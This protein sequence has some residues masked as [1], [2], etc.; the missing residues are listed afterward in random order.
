MRKNLFILILLAFIRCWGSGGSALAQ[1]VDITEG[2]TATSNG[3]VSGGED[4]TKAFDN[5]TAT[6]FNSN[7]SLPLTVQYDFAGNNAYAVNSYTVSS[8]ND[9]PARD[10]R[11]WQFQGSN[12]GTNWTTKKTSLSSN[13]ITAI[14]FDKNGSAWI[15]TKKGIV[16]LK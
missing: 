7:H 1:T 4:V 13:F 6:K 8:A 5:T 12:D 9:A 14:A 10:P 11:D 3:D 2:G 16:N 15:G